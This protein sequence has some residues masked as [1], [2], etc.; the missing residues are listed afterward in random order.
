MSRTATIQRGTRETDITLNLDLDGTGR[1]AV[2]TG[3]GFLDHMMTALAFHAGWDLDLTCRGDLAV[4]DHHTAEDCALVLGKAFDGALGDLQDGAAAGMARHPSGF[5]TSGGK[6][7]QKFHKLLS[8][9]IWHGHG[10]ES[11]ILVKIIGGYSMP[12][13][14]TSRAT[15]RPY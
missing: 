9:H 4:D 2:A 13:L 3:I 11:S 14:H 12:E 6:A 8:P 10:S 15:H 5:E 7:R 1:I